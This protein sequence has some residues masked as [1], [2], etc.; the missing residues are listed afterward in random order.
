[1]TVPGAGRL[2]DM[3]E[4]GPSVRSATEREFL[5]VLRKLQTDEAELE[6]L[7]ATVED[8]REELARARA[9]NDELYASAPIGY[10]TLDAEARIVSANPRLARLLNVNTRRL[11]GTRFCD[12][13]V[14]RERE[15]VQTLLARTRSGTQHKSPPVHL[16]SLACAAPVMLD[17]CRRSSHVLDLAVIELSGLFRAQ[18]AV[19]EREARLRAVLDAAADAIVT[20]DRSGRIDSCNTAAT[21]LFKASPAWLLG[22]ELKRLVPEFA[23]PDRSTRTELVARCA[24]DSTAPVEVYAAE[25]EPGEPA[26]LVVCLTDISE[27]K[28]RD[29]ELAETLS[30]FREMAAHIDDALYVL[31]SR[32]GEALYVSPAFE[33]IFGRALADVGEEAW[34]SLRSVHPDDRDRVA[35]AAGRLFSEGGSMNLSFRIV[36][37]DGSIRTVRSRASKI[38]GQD[39][40]TGL[41][42]D[43]TEE[44]SMQ[45]ELRQAQRLEAIGTLAS[46]VA[47]DFNN[48]LMGVGGCA[49]L[50][51]RRLDPEHEAYRYLR[52]AADAIL[53]GA[54][55]TRQILRF[56]DSRATSDEPVELDA[57][58]RGARDL[59]Q[60]LVGEP[61]V[62]SIL[63]GAPGLAV[64]ADAGD[65][66]QLLLNLA[67][68]ARDAMPEGGALRLRTEPRQGGTVAL[69]VT[70]TG[71]GMDE[72]TK[73]RVF[74]PF[75]TTKEVGKGTGLGLSTVFALVRRMGGTIAID[76]ALRQGTTF[77][78]CFPVVIPEKEEP[79]SHEDEAL[80]GAG[81]TVLIVDDDALIRMTVETHLESLG[82]RALVASSVSEA[83]RLYT[84]SQHPV[85]VVLTDV[86]MPGLLGSD[87]A[88]ILQKSAPDAAVVYMSAHPL[89]ELTSKGHVPHDAPVLTKPFDTKDLGVVLQRVIRNKRPSRPPSPLRIFVV[90]DNPD[91]VDA[92]R[93]LLEMEAY[94]V[95]TAKT[96]GDALRQI[97]E[98]R[99]D[100]VLC[101]INLEEDMNGYDLVSRL[102]GDARLAN[103]AFLAVTGLSPDQC[104]PAA[105]AAG[106]RDV[107]A[108]PLE[109]NRLTKVL[110]S[111][112][113][114]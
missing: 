56:S 109:F 38:P 106:F 5:R 24:D 100:V 102:R 93:E 33:G 39:R 80:Q 54:N 31:D 6:V 18:A 49:Q 64:T 36:R 20:V 78:L 66:E 29:A 91:V 114:R 41:L 17:V 81:Q 3:L 74:E 75:F 69:S 68:N 42:H 40:V 59:I 48:L 96:A 110:A 25:L 55:L 43:M 61:V 71:T 57:V 34:P 1:M 27:R 107:L 53:R 50:A 87:L 73:R 63:P 28:R 92:L 2:E 84:R 95:G 44:L 7:R 99:P 46:G 15:L 105:L 101:D 45:A 16:Q 47:H 8:L 37:P 89:G 94:V 4:R 35:A 9:R 103:T 77:T 13:V 86:M 30:R 60:S 72:E 19:R 83:L 67:S 70:D 82:Y 112:L 14:P 21:R 85:D 97:P 79:R 62:L 65:I 76:S 51:L 10:A 90:D 26:Q 22:Q 104:R 88:R 113:E 32:T 11:F 12:W 98:F 108:K 111:A 58:V 23:T 52:R